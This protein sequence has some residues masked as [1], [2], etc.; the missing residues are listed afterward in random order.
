MKLELL[1]SPWFWKTQIYAESM[2]E[3]V[4][5]SRLIFIGSDSVYSTSLRN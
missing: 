2:S 3:Q 5:T 4:N 1:S